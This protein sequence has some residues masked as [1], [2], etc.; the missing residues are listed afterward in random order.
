MKTLVKIS[1]VTLLCLYQ[2]VSAA[3]TEILDRVVALVDSDVILASEL[4]RR[5]NTVVE[6]IK[7]RKQTVPPI[8][9]LKDQVLER[10][11]SESLQMQMAKRAGVRIGD[12]ELDATL[13][14]IAEDSQ[15]S[16]ASFKQKVESEGTPWGIF[17]EDIRAEIMISRART[18]FVSRRIKV[19]DKEV[20]NLV[21]QINKQGE[22]QTQYSIGHI[23]LPIAENATQPTIDKTRENAQK[24]VNELRN[25]ASFEELA[26]TY[27]SGQNAL[28]GGDLGWRTLTQLPSLFADSIKNLNKGDISEPLRSG[29]GLHILK[30]KE[31]KGGFGSHE[32]LQTK[33]RHILVTPNAILSDQAAK[34]KAELIRQR[35]LNGEDFAELA[36]E[37]S[38]DKGSGSLGGDL[39]WAVPSDFVPEFGEA[40]NKLAVDEISEVVKS[41]FGYHVIQVLGRRNQDQTQEKKRERAY[42]ILHQRKFEEE[43]QLWLREL[44]DQA[45]IKIVDES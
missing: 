17:R 14:K 25:G 29:S 32:V 33:A 18:G 4:V 16:L 45:Y 24:L 6:Q 3:N 21:E 41:E 20:E 11:I 2:T 28:S 39:G 42:Q 38:D 27:S 19:S 30:L 34:E 35:V 26:V 12:A 8:N 43:S 23:L 10:L 22:S 1:C 5:T 13:Q 15:L 9:K 40:M 31:I 37:L 7:Q 36:I 44:R